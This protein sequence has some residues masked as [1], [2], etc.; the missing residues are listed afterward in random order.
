MRRDRIW[1]EWSIKEAFDAPN[2]AICGRFDRQRERFKFGEDTLRHDPVSRVISQLEWYK[3]NTLD[4]I[5]LQKQI[6]DDSR[7][8][9]GQN[10][11]KGLTWPAG[12]SLSCS[13]S[14]AGWSGARTER[15]WYFMG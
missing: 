5:R 10:A 6:A 15:D 13:T 14:G 11:G 3:T 1:N 2:V 9:W 12:G 4:W 7:G 8:R